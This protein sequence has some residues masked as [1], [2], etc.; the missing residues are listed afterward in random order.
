M[1][2]LPVDIW[3]VLREAVPCR[4]TVARRCSR[5]PHRRHDLHFPLRSPHVVSPDPR[6]YHRAGLQRLGAPSSHYTRCLTRPRWESCPAGPG[7]AIRKYRLDW[8]CVRRA[9]PWRTLS[10]CPG[11]RGHARPFRASLG[12]RPYLLNDSDPGLPSPRRSCLPAPV[13]LEDS[14]APQAASARSHSCRPSAHLPRGPAP[15][16]LT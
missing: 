14:L 12:P 2:L 16:V 6:R 10:H 1:L 13:P 11:R 8:R 15:G 9:R 5:C 4:G 7:R 3:H